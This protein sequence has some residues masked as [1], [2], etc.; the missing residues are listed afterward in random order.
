MLFTL[1]IKVF[2]VIAKISYLMNAITASNFSFTYLPLT[3]KLP[4]FQAGKDWQTT[5]IWSL[6]HHYY[7]FN[8]IFNSSILK[9]FEMQKP[10]ISTVKMQPEAAQW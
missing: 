10:V 8:I 7:K 6:S 4:L 2:S 1:D 9:M 5:G 3:E